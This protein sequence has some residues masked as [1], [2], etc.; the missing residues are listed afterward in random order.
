MCGIAGIARQSRAGVTVDSLGRMAAAIRHRGPDGYGFY[1]GRRVGLAHVRL[2]I[3]DLAGGAQPLTNEDGQIVVSYNGEIYNHPELR[4]Q[5]EERGHVFRTHSDTEV[6]V[7]GYEE[8]GTE[9]LHRLNG[10]FAF[11]I[12]DRNRETVFVARDRFGVRPLFYAQRN[13]N[14]YFGSEIKA[15]LASGEV[16]ATLDQRGLDEVLTFWGAR[17]PRTAFDGI[18]SL[19]PGTYGIW[20]DGALWL[21]HYYELDYPEA[22]DEPVDVI[23]QL[24]ELMLRSVGMRMRADVP[25]GAYVSGGLDSSITASLAA[26]ASPHTLRSFSIAFED[27]RFDES[28]YQR[29]VA[30]AI[31]SIHEVASIGSQSIAEIFPKVLWQSETPLLRTAPVPMYQLAKLTKQS[32]IKVVLTGEGA[33]ELFLGYDL[34][35]E[36]SVR[37]FC[38]RRPESVYRQ[39]LF[40]RLY[41]YLSVP[42]RGGE[43]WRR[44]FLEAGQPSD[45]LFSHLPRFLLSSRTKEF[46]TPEFRTGLGGID[47]I[48]ELRASLPTRFFAWSPLNRAAYL[49]MTTLLSTYLLSSQGDRMA[50]AHGVEGRFP[51]LDHRLFE[52]AAALPTGS[53]L[54][55][56]REKEVLRRWAARVLPPRIKARGKQ[57]YRAP[58]APSFFTSGAPEWIADHLTADA[59]KRV[60]VFSPMAV[61]GLLRRCR[62]GLATSFRENQAMVG[63]L[64]TQLW[65]HQFIESAH[66]VVPLGAG[67]ASVLLGDNAPI[68][69]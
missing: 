63:V 32:G 18:A 14:F 61:A 43:F 33:D 36:V 31:G 12:Y 15:I 30:A 11:A 7:H 37:R 34:F 27:P 8:W 19:E 21:R 66:R 20:K 2:S 5:L 49:E 48:A 23:E 68:L 35:K 26:T 55:G 38:L 41:P 45:P 64:S 13:G 6:L 67:K 3:I 57:P 17:P 65:H 16:E 22:S 39:R 62:S 25:V 60:G 42:N 44:F 46:Y 51:F 56:L 28:V 1:V 54:R 50:M 40:D 69:T 24:D 58:D 4:R 9:V 53:R 52:F 47:V 10:Q 59:L 29:E